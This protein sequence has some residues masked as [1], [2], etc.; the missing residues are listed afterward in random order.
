[1]SRRLRVVLERRDAYER[2]LNVVSITRVRVL[3]TD[4]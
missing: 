1:M 3:Q 4:G 2:P